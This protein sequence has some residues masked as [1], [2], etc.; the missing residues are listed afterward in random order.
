[1]TALVLQVTVEQAKFILDVLGEMPTNRNVYPL[2]NR[3]Y[4][5]AQGQIEM[6]KA[7]EAE[8]EANQEEKK[9]ENVPVAPKRKQG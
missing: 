9:E 5:D 3:L 1:M 7:R 2:W 4:N 8:K 6:Q